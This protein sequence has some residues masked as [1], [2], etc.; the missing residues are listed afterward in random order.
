MEPTSGLSIEQAL[1][2]GWEQG[3]KNLRTLLW[4]LGAGFLI[5]MFQN[6]LSANEGHHGNPIGAASSA[7]G[8]L[9]LQIASVY[10]TMVWVR[11]SLRIRDGL[12]LNLREAALAWPR[13]LEFLLT[14]VLYALIVAGGL[15]LLIVPG[16]IWAAQF[17]FGIYAVVDKPLDPIAALRRSSSLTRGVKGQVLLFGLALFGINLVGALAFGLGL[18]ITIPLTALASAHAYR[19]LEARQQAG[20]SAGPLPQ[21]PLPQS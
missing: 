2:F 9:I 4:P 5:W 17:A 1:R 18:I 15:I 14:Y 8:Q 11:I 21:H 20:L 12:P 3:R 7:F 19:Q 10:L 16:V 13:F 6:A